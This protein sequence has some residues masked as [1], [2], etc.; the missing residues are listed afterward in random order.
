MKVFL[1]TLIVCLLCAFSLKAADATVHWTLVPDDTGLSSQPA[2]GY[3]LYYGIDSAAVMDLA[4][5]TGYIDYSDYDDSLITVVDHLIV[6]GSVGDTAT[7]VIT[8][9]PTETDYW[10]TMIAYDQVGNRSAPGNIPKWRAV[11]GVPPSPVYI[12]Q[13]E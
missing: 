5:A 4:S 2:N 11:D 8:G 6:P 1:I 7:Y 9:L 3:T 10:F 13:L 12:I